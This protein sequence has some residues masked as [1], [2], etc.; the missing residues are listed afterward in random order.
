MASVYADWGY[1]DLPQK[2]KCKIV[3]NNFYVIYDE[4]QYHTYWG[5]ERNASEPTVPFDIVISP[6]S[7]NHEF[8]QEQVVSSLTKMELVHKFENFGLYSN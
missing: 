8:V 4:T 1:N 7:P 2:I 6:T 5:I 3:V